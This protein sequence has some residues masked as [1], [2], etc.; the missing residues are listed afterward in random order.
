MTCGRARRRACTPQRCASRGRARR[1][2]APR[3]Q[4]APR[5][6]PAALRQP[7][8]ASRQPPAALMA[9]W[10]FELTDSDRAIVRA[11]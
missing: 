4:P 9:F 1:R 3:P 10:K 5:R 2:P 6:P 11:R 8:A 7:P